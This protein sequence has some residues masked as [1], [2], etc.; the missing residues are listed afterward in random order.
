MEIDLTLLIQMVACPPF[1]VR[2]V[3]SP[4]PPR[5]LSALLSPDE[6]SWCQRPS[7]K[8]ARPFALPAKRTSLAA[9]ANAAVG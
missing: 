8:T 9:A 7:A 3:T 6:F 5:V 1:R 4:L 2:L